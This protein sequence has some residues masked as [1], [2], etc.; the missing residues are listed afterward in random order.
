MQRQIS[1]ATICITIA[2]TPDSTS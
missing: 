1:V 2:E